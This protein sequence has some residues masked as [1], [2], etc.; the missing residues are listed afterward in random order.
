LL[1]LPPRD[2]DQPPGFLG[3]ESQLD[4]HRRRVVEEPVSQRRVDVQLRQSAL[5]LG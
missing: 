1:D 2:P 5:H 3:G 4:A